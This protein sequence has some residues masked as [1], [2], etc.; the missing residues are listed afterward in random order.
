MIEIKKMCKDWKDFSLKEINLEIKKGEYF[1]ILGPTGAGKT[2]LLEMIAGFHLPDEGE[3]WIDGEDVTTYPPE[4]RNI[5]FIYQD[6]S[7]FPHLS[8][9]GNIRFGPELKGIPKDDIERESNEIMRLLGISHLSHRYP[10]T[11]SGGEQQKVAIARAIITRPS[12]LLLDEPLSALDRRTQD[13]LRVNA[14][15][16]YGEG[17]VKIFVRPEDILI[18]KKM[19]ESSA[20]NSIRGK[21]IKITNFGVVI[22]LQLDNGLIASVTKLSAEDLKLRIG[23]EV[24]ASFKATSVHVVKKKEILER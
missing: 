8:V 21:I 7:L 13:L 4:D 9:I 3:I 17:E 1:V 10:N 11:L 22:H 20:R 18:S 23:G 15:S 16:D 6:Y 2:L 5:G 19:Q 24:Y 14:V 12:V